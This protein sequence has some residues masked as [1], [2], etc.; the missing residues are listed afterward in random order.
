MDR[1]GYSQKDC[2][3][4]IGRLGAAPQAVEPEKFS[5]TG[6]VSTHPAIGVSTGTTVHTGQGFIVMSIAIA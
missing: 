5:I 3:I 6:E 4:V 1:L 2:D